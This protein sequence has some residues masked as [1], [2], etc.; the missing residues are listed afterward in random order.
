[1]V[2]V[3]KHDG[4]D[5]SAQGQAKRGEARGNCFWGKSGDNSGVM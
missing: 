3:V 4:K 5:G 1:M 2:A